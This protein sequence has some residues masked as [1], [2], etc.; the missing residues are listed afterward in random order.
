ML[1][2]RK[3]SGDNY[4][5]SVCH[6]VLDKLIDEVNSEHSPRLEHEIISA[7]ANLKKIGW[8]ESDINERAI[9]THM[10]SEI[11]NSITAYESITYAIFIIKKK[12]TYKAHI[13]VEAEMSVELIKKAIAKVVVE[14]TNEEPIAII[15]EEA[16]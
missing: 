13:E 4:T 6:R 8:A 11:E 12:R 14:H 7:F 5:D 16:P 1:S 3:K 2:L 9:I 15:V 10:Q